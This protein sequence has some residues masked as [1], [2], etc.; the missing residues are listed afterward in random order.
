MRGTTGHGHC[1]LFPSFRPHCAPP[2]PP[3][4]S[5]P[6]WWGP[7]V[8][9]QNTMVV[10]GNSAFPPQQCLKVGLWSPWSQTPF[11]GL[12]EVKTISIIAL[13][14]RLSFSFSFSDKTHSLEF[15]RSHVILQRLNEVV[16]ARASLSP[17]RPDIEE[18]ANVENSAPPLVFFYLE[19]I[20]MFL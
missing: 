10:P 17:V 9:A 1:R 18:S 8:H 2:S 6:A 20:T 4:L 13:R 7:G 12:H 5:P 15:S 11:K 14:C 3:P 19:N 16:D